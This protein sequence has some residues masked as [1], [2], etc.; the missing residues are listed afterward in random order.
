MTSRSSTTPSTG[1]RTIDVGHDGRA[2]P[3][4]Q[5]M[6][7]EESRG[8]DLRLLYVALTR[9]QHQAVLW[10]AGVQDSQHSP[11]ARLLFDRDPAGLVAAVRRGTG[12]PTPK[13]RRP[14]WRSVTTS[15]S[16]SR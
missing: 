4:H 6:E 15:R 3:I 10:W 5:K 14:S 7:L 12:T 11:L 13:W 2:F 9:A 1:K 16:S 8:E